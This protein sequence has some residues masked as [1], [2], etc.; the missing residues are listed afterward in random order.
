MVLGKC[1]EVTYECL[2]NKSLLRKKMLSIN[3]RTWEAY[4]K[5]CFLSYCFLTFTKEVSFTTPNIFRMWTHTE[6]AAITEEEWPSRW[7]VQIHGKCLPMLRK[8][9][10]GVFLCCSYLPLQST[11]CALNVGLILSTK[12]NTYLYMNISWCI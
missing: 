11:A 2:N 12:V 10:H 9:M 1:S 8:E 3:Q 7:T 6:N 5:I 4:N